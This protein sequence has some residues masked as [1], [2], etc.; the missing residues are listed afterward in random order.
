[1]KKIK[2]DDLE[3]F[4]PGLKSSLDD[5]PR[6]ERSKKDKAEPET[7]SARQ[8]ASKPARKR[9]STQSTPISDGDLAGVI[10]ALV[11]EKGKETTYVRVTQAEKQG[12]LDVVYT[13]RRQNVQLAEND[14]ARIAI[15]ALMDDYKKN[16]ENSLLAKVIYQMSSS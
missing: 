6:I 13:Y 16:G 4:A 12:L 2:P 15:A 9:A 11:K 14:V 5:M 10:A 3:V 1:M 7:A 8:Q